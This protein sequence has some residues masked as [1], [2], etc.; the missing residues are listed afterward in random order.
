MAH[1]LISQVTPVLHADDAV[2]SGRWYARLGF[3][4]E[5]SHRFDGEGPRFDTLASPAGRIFLSEHGE[6]PAG[7]LVYLHVDD[8]DA[9]AEAV[10]G[11]AADMP[12][13]MRE[14][15]VQDPAGNV[16]RIGMPL[17]D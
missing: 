8:V 12:W 6:T 4:L 13:G 17:P 3:E 14:A 10:G 11:E 16:V 1:S 15:R 7:S 2:A 5:F 9:A